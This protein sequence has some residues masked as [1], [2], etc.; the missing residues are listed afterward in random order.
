MFILFVLFGIPLIEIL[1][2]FKTGEQIGIFATIIATILTAAVGVFLIKKQ[3]IKAL[4]T[5]KMSIAVGDCPVN[6]ALNGIGILAAA[7]MLFL[8]GFFTDS[9]GLCLFIPKLRV[10]LMG[11]ILT[12][13]SVKRKSAGFNQ[14]SMGFSDSRYGPII[15]VKAEPPA[16]KTES[17]KIEW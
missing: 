7:L 4:K 8:P 16:T 6:E 5:T 2:F 9:I 15:D 17:N 3:G 10:I 11:K 14:S 1:L 12:R 13:F